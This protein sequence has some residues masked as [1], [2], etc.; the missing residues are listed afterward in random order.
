MAELRGPS[1]ADELL[2]PL[3]GSKLMVS[4]PTANVTLPP[5][6]GVL[7]AGAAVVDVVTFSR[8]VW[9]LGLAIVVADDPGF[10]VVLVVE[11]AF[12]VVVVPPTAAVVEVDPLWSGASVVVV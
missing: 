3:A 11:P 10:L 8:F 7:P 4:A 9:V 6:L 2:D 1:V 12:A 5:G